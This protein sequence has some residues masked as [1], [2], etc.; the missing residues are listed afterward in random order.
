M[1]ITAI[2]IG[3]SRIIAGVHFPKD[4]AAAILISLIWAFIGY[5]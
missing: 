2:I 3:L 4:V 1:L 5:Y